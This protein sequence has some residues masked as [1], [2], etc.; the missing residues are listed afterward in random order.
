MLSVTLKFNLEHL[1][2]IKTP[3]HSFMIILSNFNATTI[4]TAFWYRESN[5]HDKSM[6]LFRKL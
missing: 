3:V 1:W 6:P 2:F 5:S 4:I